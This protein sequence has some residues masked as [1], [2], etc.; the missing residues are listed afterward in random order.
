MKSVEA[1]ELIRQMENSGFDVV[2][3]PHPQPRVWRCRGDAAIPTER[4]FDPEAIQLFVSEGGDT[5]RSDVAYS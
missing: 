3:R 5:C 1:A 2:A 4:H